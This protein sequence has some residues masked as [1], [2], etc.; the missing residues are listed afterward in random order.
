MD[1]FCSNFYELHAVRMSVWAGKYYC[2]LYLR[3]EEQ[4]GVSLVC[5]VP[6]AHT[7]CT[8]LLIKPGA[9]SRSLARILRKLDLEKFTVVG[10]KHINLEPDV[11]LGLLPPEVKQVC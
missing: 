11:A 2:M 6:G 10:M 1:L 9:W 3:F 8:V 5:C 4:L 7:L